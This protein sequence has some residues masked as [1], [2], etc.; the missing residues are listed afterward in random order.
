MCKRAH[1]AGCGTC[2]DA[3]ELSGRCRFEARRGF[4]DYVSHPRDRLT[5]GHCAQ[6]GRLHIGDGQQRAGVQ[7]TAENISAGRT[8]M[9]YLTTA[10]P[11]RAEA[12]CR[13]LAVC[14]IEQA[15]RDLSASDASDADRE[16]ARGFLSGSPML[17]RWCELANVNAS[18]TMEWATRL[19]EPSGRLR[20]LAAAR[21]L[22]S[23]R[24]NNSHRS[25]QEPSRTVERQR[26]VA[27]SEGSQPGPDF[28]TTRLA[29]VP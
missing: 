15:V 22:A 20:T 12:A 13:H 14:V 23:S 24:R 21:E 8:A 4:R 28:S 5:T 27:R 19:M 7:E 25:T 10:E 3:R 2:H 9:K 29:R 6:S 16:S 1:T 17:Y 11:T 26:G 18:W